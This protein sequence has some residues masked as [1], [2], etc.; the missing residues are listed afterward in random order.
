MIICYINNENLIKFHRKRRKRNRYKFTEESIE[1]LLKDPEFIAMLEL[2]RRMK[3]YGD[4]LKLIDN[5]NKN[6]P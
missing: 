2:R 4:K 1:K 3:L 5:L 6:I